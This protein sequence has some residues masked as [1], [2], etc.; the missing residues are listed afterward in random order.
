MKHFKSIFAIGV[1]ALFLLVSVSHATAVK[2]LQQMTAI[3]EEH[4]V[5]QMMDLIEDAAL[6]SSSFKEFIQRLRDL[7][8]RFDF[9]TFPIVR[10]LLEKVIDI[11]SGQT[12]FTVRGRSISGIRDWDIF[13]RRVIKHFVMSYGVYNRMN[14]FKENEFRISKEGMT[15]WRYGGVSSLFRGRTL[16][17][18][19]QPF[20]IKQRMLGSHFGLMTGFRGMFLDMESRL[21]GN[22]YVFFM[23]RAQR[24]RAFDLTPFNN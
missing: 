2:P 3:K 15:F 9:T 24:I 23:G 11:S 4:A 18:E 1:I 5:E 6:R 13:N 12:G 17:I 8:S 16:I 21:T 10:K 7:L 19:R 22:S 14:P 20:G